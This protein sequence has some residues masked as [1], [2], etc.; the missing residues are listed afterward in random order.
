MKVY[1]VM[2]RDVITV[3]PETSIGEAA[4]LMTTHGVSG[5]PVID[6]RGAVVGILSE[7]DLILRQKQRERAPW[8]RS[9][10]ADGERLAREY[11]KAVGTTAGEVM[12]RSVLCVSPD[13]SIEAAA[14]ILD[15]RRI[16]RLPV[17]AN[18]RLVGIVSRGDLIKAVANGV[19]PDTS[20]A[21]SDAQLVREMKERIARESWV[22]HRGILVQSKERVLSLWGLV[23]S[24]AEKS[25]LETMARA[26]KGV[27]GVESH[28]V[29]RAEMPYLYWG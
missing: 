9:F 12:T 23:N 10:F 11:Q 14:S 7:G 13:L 1:E 15:A 29:V 6:E 20:P 17:M 21:P 16:R 28:L 26:I 27:R 3:R 19:G 8:W 18:G 24:E 25:A 2:T 22:S 4:Q 5:L